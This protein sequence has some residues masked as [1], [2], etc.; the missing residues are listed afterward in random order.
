MTSNDRDSRLESLFHQ[1]LERPADERE[2]LLRAGCGD[3]LRLLDELRELLDAHDEAPRVLDEPAWARGLLGLGAPEHAASGL[4]VGPYELLALLG[5]GGMGSVYRAR[6]HEPLRREVALKLVKPGMDTREVLARFEAERQLLARLHHPNVAAVYDA[7]ST[8]QGRPYF[9]MELVDGEPVTRWCDRRR[10]GIAERLRLFVTVCAAVQHAHQK[11]VVHRDLKPGNVLVAESDGRAVAKVIDFGVAKALDGSLEAGTWCTRQGQLIGTPG[12]MSPEQALGDRNRIDTRSDVYSL[13]VLLQELLSG[14]LPIEPRSLRGL[15]DAAVRQRVL[16]IR[17][18]AP[19]ERLAALPSM[20]RARRAARRG[21]EPK[22]LRRQL[23]GDLDWV[24]LK[25]TAAEPGARHATASELAA[26]V[27]AYL[28]AEPVSA[29]PPGLGYRLGK[30]SRRHRGPAAA[31]AALL[32]AMLSLPSLLAVWQGQRIAEMERVLGDRDDGGEP[33]VPG[34]P[35]GQGRSA[36][37]VCAACAEGSDQPVDLVLV[38]N[39]G[40]RDLLAGDVL[41]LDAEQ[42]ERGRLVFAVRPARAGSERSL[43]GSFAR[44]VQVEGEHLHGL[45]GT[46][47]PGG[48]GQAVARGSLVRVRVDGPVPARAPLAASE[49]AGLAAVGSAEEPLLGTVQ[50]GWAGPGPGFVRAA[51]AP[52]W[53]RPDTTGAPAT[54]LTAGA[55]RRPVAPDGVSSTRALELLAAAG[56][57]GGGLP[58]SDGLDGG[59]DIDTKSLPLVAKGKR[60]RLAPD[61]P[62]SMDGASERNTWMGSLDEA[63]ELAPGRGQRTT[64]DPTKG[65]D[66]GDDED[67]EVGLALGPGAAA[68]RGTSLHWADYDADG[69]DDLLLIRD[70]SLD[71]LRNL[72]QGLFQDVSDRLSLDHVGTVAQALWAPLDG[73]ARVDLL[74]RDTN[75][76]LR[77]LRSEGQ[78]QLVD[79][80]Q[81]S[82][83]EKVSTLA[84]IELA[85]PDLDGRVGVVAET[86]HGALLMLVNDGNARF[87]V[88]VLKAAV[89]SGDELTSDEESATDGS[90]SVGPK[91]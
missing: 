30:L 85:D 3:D 87:D 15:D 13:G 26:D 16:A 42:I 57:D 40:E 75:G 18:T 36:Q 84:W 88:V 7:G 29:G 12:Y 23:R 8:E 62:A 50:A 41:E 64:A 90:P 74:L 81:G 19:S 47:P 68:P 38:R 39:V 83:L 44:A 79:R 34:D 51:I 91:G 17:P 72:G 82:G 35:S 73:D 77:L 61:S 52:S 22:V 10:L 4:R 53:P 58:G 54:G 43:L 2:A 80:T 32:L 20:G 21:C 70:G 33:G 56:G 25:A 31:A 59:H 78:G 66:Q 89:Q 46:L 5:E 76:S 45:T 14:T 69:L 27:L 9:V 65:G 24:V 28:A 71:L 86:S 11:G 63:L 6:Q 48:L 37:A 67:P 49:V 1:A 60:F 55:S